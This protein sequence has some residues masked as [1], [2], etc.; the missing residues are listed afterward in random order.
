MYVEKPPKSLWLSAGLTIA[1]VA[2]GFATWTAVTTPNTPTGIVP[3]VVGVFAA[4]AY[5]VAALY[6]MEYRITATDL[7]IVY[8]PFTFRIARRSIRAVRVRSTPWWMGV[9]VKIFGRRIAF[10]TRWGQIVEIEKDSG[11]FRQV[12]LSPEDPERFADRLKK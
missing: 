6:F 1:L 12:W 8:P 4:A 2:A 9:G 5:F 10:T 3:I 11:V 7:Q